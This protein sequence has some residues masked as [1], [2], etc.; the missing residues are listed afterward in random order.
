MQ[1]DLLLRR[2]RTLGPEHQ[3]TV[4]A[5][6]GLATML[7]EDG[8]LEEA[9]A[10]GRAALDVR[11]RN[12]PAQ[13]PDR[14]E[15]EDQL[16]RILL[17]RGKVAEAAEL[18]QSAL[19]GFEAVAGAESPSTITA[20]L[21]AWQIFERAGDVQRAA[22]LR[23]RLLEPLLTR[24]PATLSNTLRGQRERIAKALAGGSP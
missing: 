21:G 12:L 1:R 9:E 16:A 5:R 23:A 24:D 22:A 2:E 4:S 13:H 6:L 11:R 14:F 8:Q 20:A 15:T 19:D 7:G 10:A 3:D 18:A 17:D